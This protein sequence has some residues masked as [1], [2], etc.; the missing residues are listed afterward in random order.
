MV[1]SGYALGSIYSLEDEP[2]TIG[3][4]PV[5]TVVIED[6]GAS[7]RHVEIERLC[8]R[9]VIR[10]AGSKNGTFVNDEQIEERL[11]QDGDL[12]HVG[13]TTYK[14]LAG[15]NV[16]HSYYE[17]LHEVAMQCALT[18]LP[19][20]RYFDE[21][22]AREMARARRHGRRLVLLLADLDRFKSINDD[23]GHVAGDMVLRE[24]S[25]LIRDRVRNSEFFARFGGEEFAFV[26]PE[27]DIE[28]AWIFAETIRRKIEA[29]RFDCNGTILNVT[30]CI[31]GAALT[32]DMK[33]PED[34]IA[35]ADERLYEAKRAGRNRVVL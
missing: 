21:V 18:E 6:V 11:L 5:N 24:F 22:L 10:D 25:R 2:M 20:R 16:E 30:V 14:F 4:D 19:N 13:R 12:I 26:M 35:A 8:E 28:G 3:R 23:H 7:R 15:N 1:V 33:G 34:L 29:Q 32:E 9:A 17:G 31:G 27:A